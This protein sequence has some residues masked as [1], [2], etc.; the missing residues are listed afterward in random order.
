MTLIIN[1]AR[2]VRKFV[3]LL[4]NKYH[5]VGKLVYFPLNGATF[6]RKMNVATMKNFPNLP[7]KPFFG[8]VFLIG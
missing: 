7:S 8:V 3:L 2:K 1:I 4:G 6:V 5:T